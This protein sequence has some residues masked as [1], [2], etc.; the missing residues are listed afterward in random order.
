MEL[1]SNCHT[2]IVNQA[3]FWALRPEQALV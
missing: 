3:K 2:T 1:Y